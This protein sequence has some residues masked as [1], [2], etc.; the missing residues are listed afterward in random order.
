MKKL[1]KRKENGDIALISVFASIV[2]LTILALIID[3][4]LI[5]YQSARLQNA[6]DSATVAVAHNLMADDASVKNTVETYMK[7]NGV[8]ITEKGYGAITPGTLTT[9]ITYGDE[10]AIVLIDK[11]GLLTEEAEDADDGRYITAGYLK[12]TVA[13]K[14]KGY[15]SAFSGLTGK[16]IVKSGYAKCD[17]QYNDMPE[18][19]KYTIFGNSPNTTDDYRKMTV[20]IDG[21]TN[22]TQAVANMFVKIING[23][24]ESFV[25]PIIGAF[26]GEPNYN[27]LLNA[28]LSHAIVNG[29]VHSN[30]DI[31]IG[32]NTIQASRAKDADFNG[33]QEECICSIKC[34][35][36]SVNHYC[37]VCQSDYRKC[38]GDEQTND[39]YNQVIF[40]AV[41]KIDF[42]AG[43][44]ANNSFIG[45]VIGS[46][47]DFETRVYVRNF[48]YVEQTQV[49]LYV[50]DQID[51][52]T[53]TS[54]ETLRSVFTQTAT[55]YFTNSI[56]L[57]ESQ[58]NAILAQA[59]NLEYISKNKYRLNAQKSIVYAA[60]NAMAND[61]M[62]AVQ[63]GN[64]LVN[65]LQPVLDSGGIDPTAT[66]ET[67]LK[68]DGT[69][70]DIENSVVTFTKPDSD[71]TAELYIVDSENTNRSVIDMTKQSL[72]T[73]SATAGYRFAV[74]KTFHQFAN[75]IDAPNM[76]PYFIR[77]INRSV[78]NATTTKDSDSTA[79]EYED[80]KSV[81]DAV[82][83]SQTRLV[84]TI[85]S[86]NTMATINNGD[87]TFSKGSADAT[88]D[89]SAVADGQ[90]DTYIDN[91]YRT[92]ASVTRQETSPLFRYRLNSTTNDK[93][94]LVTNN[95]NG[96]SPYTLI[97]YGNND[98]GHTTYNG[99]K[100]FND[101]GNLSTAKEVVDDYAQ[102]NNS[103]YGKNAVDKFEQTDVLVDADADDP[104]VHDY[105]NHYGDDAVAKKKHYIENTLMLSGDS[106]FTDAAPKKE[107]VFLMS[108]GTKKSYLEQNITNIKSMAGAIGSTALAIPADLRVDPVASRYRTLIDA[109]IDD[110]G[111]TLENSTGLSYTGKGAYITKDYLIPD[112]TRV[113]V[114]YPYSDLL[115][116]V[117][118]QT[119]NI[120]VNQIVAETRDDF[121]KVE[122]S[123]DA[124]LT[125][126]EMNQA[127]LLTLVNNKYNEYHQ[128]KDTTGWT[129]RGTAGKNP[130]S[131]DFP[132]DGKQMILHDKSVYA[133]I[134]NAWA[135]GW[136]TTRYGVTI[137]SGRSVQINGNFSLDGNDS[138][139]HVVIG[140]NSD[141][142]KPTYLY[143]KGNFI[144]PRCDITIGDNTTVIVDGH[145]KTTGENTYYQIKIGNNS[146]LI[147]NYEMFINGNIEVGENSVVVVNRTEDGS[148]YSMKYGSITSKPG[149]KMYIYKDVY[150]WADG[151]NHLG[152]EFYTGGAMWRDGAGGNTYFDSNSLTYLGRDLNTN[153]NGDLYLQENA[154]VVVN[155]PTE[156]SENYQTVKVI[157]GKTIHMQA[158][159]VLVT[160]G[161]VYH[162]IDAS[163]YDMKPGSLIVTDMVKC[164][165]SSNTA[166]L[167]NIIAKKIDTNTLVFVNGANVFCS[168]EIYVANN[169]SVELNNHVKIVAGKNAN[170]ESV[171]GNSSFTFSNDYNNA[172]D[173]AFAIGCTGTITGFA[174]G[175]FVLGAGCY[176]SAQGLTI[177]NLTINQGGGF[178]IPKAQPG[179]ETNTN[180][181]NLTV[182][183]GESTYI[184]NNLNVSGTNGTITVNADLD[185]YKVASANSIVVN[186]GN[187][188]VD[189]D[190]TAT[191]IT[192]KDEMNVAN[193]LTCSGTI[194]NQGKLL[195]GVAPNGSNPGNTGS[196]SGSSGTIENFG[197]VQIYGSASFGTLYN[198]YNT[199]KSKG[200]V[201]Y[202]GVDIFNPA[203][204]SITTFNNDASCKV[205][206]PD[207]LEIQT[208]KNYGF[209]E[210][211]TLS[212]TS[213][214][215]SFTNYQSGQVKL[216]SATCEGGITNDGI[217]QCTGSFSV[218]GAVN[219]TKN[220]RLDNGCTIT[221]KLTNSDSGNVQ[222]TGNDANLKNV[223]NSGNISVYG[224][225][226]SSG[227]FVNRSFTCSASQSKINRLENS[228]TFSTTLLNRNGSTES[229]IVN[230]GTL[231]LYS[232][233]GGA[234][235]NVTS[236][237]NSGD[238]V[239]NRSVY[240]GN[241]VNTGKLEVFESLESS[242][243]ITNSAKLYVHK[244]IKATSTINNNSNGS[245][246]EG[247]STIYAG[248]GN[249]SDYA[250]YAETINNGANIVVGRDDIY[251]TERFAVLESS[252]VCVID[253]GIDTNDFELNNNCS[254]SYSNDLNIRRMLINKGNILLTEAKAKRIENHGNLYIESSGNFILD[255]LYNTESGSIAFDGGS[256][257]LSSQ[258][259]SASIRNMGKLYVNGNVYCYGAFYGIG[260][261]A[262]IYG[263]LDAANSVAFNNASI[264]LEEDAQLYV[265]GDAPTNAA[266]NGVYIKEKTDVNLPNAVYSV[267]GRGNTINS[268]TI[269]SDQ[270]S[271]K[272]YFGGNVEVS[273]T[274]NTQTMKGQSFF[275][276]KYTCASTM[277][278]NIESEGLVYIADDVDAQGTDVYVKSSGLYCYGKSIKFKNIYGDAGRIYLINLPI[279]QYTGVSGVINLSNASMIYIP[280]NVTLPDGKLIMTDD[281]LNLSDPSVIIPI[282][283]DNFAKANSGFVTSGNASVYKTTLTIPEGSTLCVGGN[284]Y[285]LG[286]SARIVVNGSLYVTGKI[287]YSDNIAPTKFNSTE[288]SELSDVKFDDLITMGGQNAEMF[289]GKT[290]SGTVNLKNEL[291][292]YGNQ[293]LYMENNLSTTGNLT[294]SER[295]KGGIGGGSLVPNRGESVI[296]EGNSKAY[297]SGDFFTNGPN[298][299]LGNAIYVAKDASLS[300]GGNLYNDS[301]I[302]NYGT[303]FVFGEM[304]NYKKADGTEASDA[305]TY[306]SD[307]K[308]SDRNYEG[309]SL[310]N[311][312]DGA[313]TARFFV[314]GHLK[315]G[316][317]SQKTIIFEGYAQNWGTVNIAQPI[318]IKGHRVNGKTW[319]RVIGENGDVSYGTRSY[320]AGSGKP[321]EN[322]PRF[323]WVAEQASHANFG[324]H[325]AL[326]GGYIG[327]N[328]DS[329]GAA[330]NMPV[331]STEGDCTYGMGILNGGIFY[332]KGAVG[333]TGRTG[334]TL[335]NTEMTGI[336]A[337][338][339][340]YINHI[341]V[342]W[343][344]PTGAEGD[345]KGSYSILNGY[346]YYSDRKTGT[347][348]QNNKAVFYAGSGVQVGYS[349]NSTGNEI[350]GS[351]SNW[352]DM[353]INGSLTVYSNKEYSINM[354]ALSAQPNSR[355]VIAGN[356]FSSGGFVTMR[357][358]LFMCDGDL[359]S[360][361][362]ARIGV[363]ELVTSDDDINYS[364]Y[365]YVGGNMVTSTNGTGGNG[366]LGSG[367]GINIASW[368]YLD[369]FSNANIYVGGSFFTNSIFHPFQN[370]T[371]VVDG[372]DKG[373][374]NTST[375]FIT[376]LQTIA[377][378]ISLSISGYN[379][380]DFK[381]IVNDRFDV[382][383]TRAEGRTTSMFDRY[384]VHGSVYLNGR[385]KIADMTKFYVYGNFVNRTD[386]TAKLSSFEVG[387][388]LDVKNDGDTWASKGTFV[389]SNDEPRTIRD[390]SGN[391]ILNPD[392]DYNYA[393][394]TYV[395]VED[396]LDVD[397][398]MDVYPGTTIK[399]GKNY[400]LFGRVKL[401]H[402]TRLYCGG[403]IDSKR[404]IDVGQYADLFAKGGISAWNYVVIREHAMLYS[405]GDVKCGTT[406]EGKTASTTY[407]EGSL[408]ATLSNIKIRD[409]STAFVSGN[410]SAFSYIELGKKDESYKDNLRKPEDPSSGNVCTCSSRC[411]GSGDEQ[412]DGDC[413]VCSSDYSRCTGPLECICESEC[414]SESYNADCP[415]CNANIAE[416]KH[417]NP[418]TIEGVQCTCK[419]TR[420]TSA[421][422]DCPVCSTDYSKCEVGG[423]ETVLEN[424][425]TR[426]LTDKANG[427]DFYIGRALI[428][429]TSYI[430]QY[431]F[432]STLVGRYVFANRYLT[433]RSNSDMWVLPEAFNND[434]YKHVDKTFESDGTIL[435]DIIKF[436]KETAFKVQ[437]KLSLKNGSIYTMGDLSL[438]KNASIMGTHDCYVFG[439]ATL[440]HDSLMYFGHDVKFYGPSFDLSGIFTGNF[441]GF[442]AA[443]DVY[444]TMKCN[445]KAKHPSGYTIY[446]KNYDP[447]KSYVCD[448]CGAALSKKTV[449][450]AV[451]CPVTIYANNDLVM[452]TSVNMSL[453]YAVACNGDVTISD[454]YSS[455]TYDDRNLYQLPNAIASYNG[456]ITYATMY[457]KI[458]ALFYAPSGNS[459]PEKTVGNVKLDGYYQEIWGSIIGD[460]VTVDTFYIN[461]HR[462]NNWRT[463]D[464]QI[465]ESGN[466]Y[467]ISKEEYDKY[468]NNVDEAFMTSGN[469]EDETKGGASLF[470]DKDIL[471]KGEV[472]GGGLE[473]TTN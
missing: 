423:E 76:K 210:A 357:N 270:Q 207:K 92:S 444:T 83:K 170:G 250:I 69:N 472:S 47:N 87:G 227:T 42:S 259:D 346:T 352:G 77:A 27:T 315:N 12:V 322:A 278:F 252:I 466:V 230:T 258:I 17:M 151:D 208:A 309:M 40:T 79:T 328:A 43:K 120:T 226:I 55:E 148:N 39:D 194:E 23:I 277:N 138:S 86:K 437:D 263:D 169:K 291:N 2:I 368:N 268:G 105:D 125:P 78:K 468:V 335:N 416:C 223:D 383:K 133:S 199:A 215:S 118:G 209:V 370:V 247:N 354:I 334:H 239:S 221:G 103:K 283:N 441:T 80:A 13:L 339:D 161:N 454:P 218:R 298:N 310:L 320:T 29:D 276:G 108:S 191:N 154:M 326:L 177:G 470:F 422:A 41:N 110:L 235:S 307:K 325:V 254:L 376:W 153:G 452:A 129:S 172:A 304:V 213:S 167:A 289:I 198:K 107:D 264:Y 380:D 269:N 68:Y 58:R 311:G 375:N 150:K 405:G 98:A 111:Y 463:I 379:K 36:N 438:N 372:K 220:I 323:S 361:R 93:N 329:T 145:F 37:S 137:K 33:K 433:L 429:Y 347:C 401:D 392:Y 216:R 190:C 147:V 260:G 465:A 241:L 173:K 25:Q 451:T 142:S 450:E 217:I 255:Y 460:T 162:R 391:Y 35:E 327:Y 63:S 381:F 297:I 457:G 186:S 10:D 313:R 333:Y 187:L 367:L 117:V 106:K 16:Q 413:P 160:L 366:D 407:T 203:T 456:N 30:S 272:L 127:N 15:W 286:T 236:I 374:V 331:F 149:S 65:M 371:I 60:S 349:E 182:N 293:K 279:S 408:K 324:N 156:A 24:N 74:A 281:C 102:K 50:L 57:P 282:S 415:V 285:L 49:V 116:K 18:A 197:T 231:E 225:I 56:T 419:D 341:E 435:G 386:L 144:V 436:I 53:I 192:V 473:Q 200:S 152:G 403:K 113:K 188:I 385:A 195:V 336:D 95:D 212:S 96:K 261:E 179:T 233:S 321:Y 318:W 448:K 244:S 75:H 262:Y 378:G 126:V 364:S 430:R 6:V 287:Y 355:T 237:D 97:K 238:F 104:S 20:R 284:L 305:R 471:N 342:F 447:T 119:P 290:N 308:E 377:N 317:V 66:P 224:Q 330:E 184:G 171:S 64:T 155:T 54:T 337:Y 178:F 343:F 22:N 240:T 11:K 312:N 388:A 251:V 439:Q 128:I 176:L 85:N 267:Y 434:T 143:V 464:L 122:P 175:D 280:K 301:A 193:T 459:T 253:G 396:T 206:C 271:S 73:A 442:T 31:S 101:E 141:T 232:T 359:I 243:N 356:A 432:S 124:S 363:S 91:T 406:Y 462:F 26:G 288:I 214:T 248:M 201:F 84:N 427:G 28:S 38:D 294:N 82:K 211:G 400:K 395:Y 467:L 314:G 455:N 296:I 461:L 61:V 453:C 275:Y 81:K 204:T 319:V 418:E 166:W 412:H 180:I 389:D 44:Y 146:K 399:I 351:V 340:Y 302:Y 414:T 135:P 410:M 70:L 8:D 273:T 421:K 158:G 365:T 362:C 397:R 316:T 398:Q 140:D 358:A 411:T 114:D 219:N 183:D 229:N 449:R 228:G 234:S 344:G 202:S 164:G 19:L 242:N 163:C 350:G 306:S 67:L 303:F 130:S 384:Y 345:K 417:V 14:C 48:Q 21:R 115:P 134:N 132:L 299:N 420:C 409:E 332:A 7:E 431:G 196:F 292:L 72:T 256:L 62:L 99:V 189:T 94:K 382:Q 249:G 338:S 402:D 393:N 4:G 5:Y 139:T 257:E 348:P 9:K 353:Y 109:T 45:S 446:T 458:A 394:A 425:I 136:S 3:F 266:G 360:K 159:S 205:I 52:D 168:D 246:G 300:C 424:D 265:Y 112:R 373:A 369:I 426:D 89:P 390:G 222:V 245:T 32:V 185:L 131:T 274:N 71:Q 59:D 100:V 469:T 445:N 387:R 34:K 295:S 157:G 46:D 174:S 88:T 51:F 90:S 123:I 440:L 121:K 1:F 404:Y 443:G 428:S 165:N 181:T